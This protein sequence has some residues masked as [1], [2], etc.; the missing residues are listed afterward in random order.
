MVVA[1]D[2]D[3]GSDTDASASDAPSVSSLRGVQD[4]HDHPD[5]P[6]TASGCAVSSG[7]VSAAIG[8]SSG[9]A[10]A[11]ASGEDVAAAASGEVVPAVARVVADPPGCLDICTQTRMGLILFT[12]PDTSRFIHT[13]RNVN[14][15]DGIISSIL[16]I[17]PLTTVFTQGYLP[18][19]QPGVD[20]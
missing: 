19:I 1:L 3:N 4:V 16:V 10:C 14:T 11:S 2:H 20:V 5:V 13:L 17:S 12:R 8:V 9:A 7:S 6:E 15:A 18:P